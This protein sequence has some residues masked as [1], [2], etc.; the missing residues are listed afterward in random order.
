MRTVETGQRV[1]TKEGPLGE[2]D[3]A[4]ER[5]EG[6]GVLAHLAV[7]LQEGN[8]TRRGDAGPSRLHHHVILIPALRLFVIIIAPPPAL[9][10]CGRCSLSC[11]LVHDCLVLPKLPDHLLKGGIL[12]EQA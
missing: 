3:N 1:W 10:R 9:F 5:A 6:E 4:E 8:G 12:P 11:H 7:V 2:H